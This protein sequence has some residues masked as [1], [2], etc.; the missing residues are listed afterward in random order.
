MILITE[1]LNNDDEIM[2]AVSGK[3]NQM[4][5]ITEYMDPSKRESLGAWKNVIPK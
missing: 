2:E 1:G 3:G 4:F 5:N